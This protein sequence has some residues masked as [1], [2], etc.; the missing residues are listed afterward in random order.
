MLKYKIREFVNRIISDEEFNIS[1]RNL[2]LIFNN[3]I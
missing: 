1:C 2:G 3:I